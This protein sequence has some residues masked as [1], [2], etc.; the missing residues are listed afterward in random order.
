MTTHRRTRLGRCAFCGEKTSWAHPRGKYCSP[1]CRAANYERLY[2][3]IGKRAK[4]AGHRRKRPKI[5]E[6]VEPAAVP[7]EFLV[8]SS[9]R[10]EKALRAGREVPGV[11]QIE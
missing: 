11:K 7:R 5:F 10:I 9:A 8:V 2:P 3:R 1:E 4:G 6:V